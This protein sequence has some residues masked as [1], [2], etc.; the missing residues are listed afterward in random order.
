MIKTQFAV[1]STSFRTYRKF[2]ALCTKAGWK[3]LQLGT[4]KFREDSM[5]EN[6]CLFF[7]NCWNNSSRFA[8]SNIY[9]PSKIE[10]KPTLIFNLDL[11]VGWDMAR[12]YMEN[13]FKAK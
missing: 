9:H 11:E 12:K 2:R 5:K 4:A 10:D 1:R 6:D 13:K 7:D 8:F 3:F